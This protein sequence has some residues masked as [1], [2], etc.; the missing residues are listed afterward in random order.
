M[1]LQAEAARRYGI[2][3]PAIAKSL[4]RSGKRNAQGDRVSKPITLHPRHPLPGDPR[5]TI[6]GAIIIVRGGLRA[7]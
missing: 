1:V 2:S 7:A 3:Q 4:S 6:H 5:T